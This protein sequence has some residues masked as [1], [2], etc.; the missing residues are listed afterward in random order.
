M[1]SVA[2]QRKFPGHPGWQLVH[3]QQL[4]DLDS[5]G[6]DFPDQSEKSWVEILVHFEELL[7]ICLFVPFCA[8]LDIV[9]P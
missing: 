5:L 4:P 6:V 1:S 2:K 7:E 8:R 9:P 3:I